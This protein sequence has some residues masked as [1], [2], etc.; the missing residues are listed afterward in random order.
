MT[1]RSDNPRQNCRKP[2]GRVSVAVV[3]RTASQ[4]VQ[5]EHRAPLGREGSLGNITTRWRKLRRKPCRHSCGGQVLASV[6]DVV[7]LIVSSRY[8]CQRHMHACRL[9]PT[10]KHNTVAHPIARAPATFKQGRAMIMALMVG[11]E[12]TQT[13]L[14]PAA[15]PFLDGA[16]CCSLT[17]SRS[18]AC[19]TTPPYLRVRA[20][21]LPSRG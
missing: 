15:P 7:L 5:F 8:A 20:C 2:R 14:V 12:S 18:L 19:P 1:F 10:H 13:G 21:V 4:A 6:C 17:R 9:S 3:P 16:V 11:G